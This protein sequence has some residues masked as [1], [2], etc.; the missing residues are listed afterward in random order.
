[1][2][3]DMD[4]AAEIDPV[5][6]GALVNAVEQ[7]E[8]KVDKLETNIEKLVELA[9]K[10]KGGVFTAMAITSFLTG[11]VSWIFGHFWK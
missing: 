10:S 3:G 5:K 6:Y 11:V 9:N 2:A 1:M 7:L 8:K 4:M